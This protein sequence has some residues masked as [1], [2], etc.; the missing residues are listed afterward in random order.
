MAVTGTST[1]MVING[2]RRGATSEALLT[3]EN[4]SEL[5]TTIIIVLR[6]RSSDDRIALRCAVLACNGVYIVLCYSVV[7]GLY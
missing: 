3:D 5:A 1:L 7:F 4:M 2:Y 6:G